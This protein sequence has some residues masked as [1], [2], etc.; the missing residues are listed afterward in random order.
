[1]L[2]SSC[3]WLLFI[4]ALAGNG[5]LA[6][7]IARTPRTRWLLWG[8]Y[9]AGLVLLLGLQI[10]VIAGAMQVFNLVVDAPVR[11]WIGRGVLIFWMLALGGAT[12][13][14]RRMDD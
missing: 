13:R 6:W 3:E 4:G 12:L 1:M 9:S 14:V 7:N 11:H 8:I 5:W 2:N 10:V